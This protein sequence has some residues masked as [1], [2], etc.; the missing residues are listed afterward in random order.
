MQRTLSNELFLFSYDELKCFDLIADDL[1]A[2][3]EWCWDD[4]SSS[5]NQL[6]SVR[7][8]MTYRFCILLH[9]TTMK[10]KIRNWFTSYCIYF[11]KAFLCFIVFGFKF[12]LWF[13]LNIKSTSL[14][15]AFYKLVWMHK[16]F[17]LCIILLAKLMKPSLVMETNR[18]IILYF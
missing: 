18:K 12:C 5:I 4:S 9:H 2:V 10:K 3:Q 6:S 8:S 17:E 11:W 16:F 1:L 14:K 7:E 15:V 13:C